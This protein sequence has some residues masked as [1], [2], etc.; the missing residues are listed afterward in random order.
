MILS[1]VQKYLIKFKG[2]GLQFESV[3]NSKNYYRY[4]WFYY[5]NTILFLLL[6]VGNFAQK[7]QIWPF[8]GEKWNLSFLKFSWL[9]QTLNNIFV[10]PFDSPAYPFNLMTWFPNFRWRNLTFCAFLSK[11]WDFIMFFAQKVRIVKLIK[12]YLYHVNT[13]PYL[14]WNDEVP[15]KC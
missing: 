13:L 14:W 15:K 7:W 8:S 10:M 9:F 2:F 1:P 12:F 11:N 4:N 5:R 6:H 3:F